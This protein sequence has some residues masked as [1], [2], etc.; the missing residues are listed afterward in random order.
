MHAVHPALYKGIWNVSFLYPET[1]EMGHGRSHS[2]CHRGS[3]WL[4]GYAYKTVGKWCRRAWGLERG[5]RSC[6]SHTHSPQGRTLKLQ[7]ICPLLWPLWAST[8]MAHTHTH[9]HTHTLTHT[10]THTHS[11]THTLTHTACEWGETDRCAD[12]LPSTWRLLISALQQ[13]ALDFPI[14]CPILYPLCGYFYF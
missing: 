11:L 9:T 5:L 14:V 13:G 2:V 3:D 10:L 12:L 1:R 8:R 6:S 7:G 4:P